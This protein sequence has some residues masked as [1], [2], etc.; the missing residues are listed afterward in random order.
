MVL[1]STTVSS[2]STGIHGV[3]DEI[4]KLQAQLSQIHD[5]MSL[6]EPPIPMPPVMDSSLDDSP[7]DQEIGARGGSS[8][9]ERLPGLRALKESLRQDLEA[10]EKVEHL[11]ENAAAIILLTRLYSS[12]FGPIQTVHHSLLLR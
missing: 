12:S 11:R 1:E 4:H 7:E 8:T 3:H 9:N 6:Y 2:S 5:D 10:L